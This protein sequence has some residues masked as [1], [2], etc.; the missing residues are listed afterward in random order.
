MAERSP[1]AI[2]AAAAEVRFPEDWISEQTRQNEAAKAYLAA[3]PQPMPRIMLNL[4]VEKD[5]WRDATP[6]EVAEMEAR[7]E[8][9]PELGDWPATPEAMEFSAGSSYPGGAPTRH[10]VILPTHDATEAPAYL[11]FGGWNACPA[12]EYQIAALRRW[13]DQFGASLATCGC[14]LLELSVARRPTGR[15]AAMA[16]AREHYD[17]CN[18]LIDQGF[19]DFAR[20]AGS[21][22]VSDWWSFWWD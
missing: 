19:G 21:L 16:L 14:D 3:H 20:L 15:E 1:Q 17:Y 18:D 7:G 4:V 6:E 12:P 10:I 13:R 22:T 8:R 2:I 11:N 5:G 9:G